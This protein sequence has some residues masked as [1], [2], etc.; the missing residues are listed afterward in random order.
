M[1]Y[2]ERTNIRTV[3]ILLDEEPTMNSLENA[4]KK[5]QPSIEIGK[6]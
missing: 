4:F 6:E 3:V 5:V 2:R 1:I